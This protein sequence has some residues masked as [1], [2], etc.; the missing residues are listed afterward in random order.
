[1]YAVFPWTAAMVS[2]FTSFPENVS[3]ALQAA[4]RVMKK[5]YRSRKH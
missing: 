5:L 4:D 3:K 1:M 2:L